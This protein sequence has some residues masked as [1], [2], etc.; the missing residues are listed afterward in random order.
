MSFTSVSIP[1]PSALHTVPAVSAQIDVIVQVSLATGLL[2]I[3]LTLLIVFKPALVKLLS[4]SVAAAKQH[5]TGS[6]RQNHRWQGVRL[7]Q[8]LAKKFDQT[9]P[10]LAAELRYLGRN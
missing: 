8:R 4:N 2:G 5:G 1:A 9:E 3:L 10:A 6:A 7:L